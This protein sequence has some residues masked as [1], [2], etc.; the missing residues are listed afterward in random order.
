VC[1]GTLSTS[2]ATSLPRGWPGLL[3]A[4]GRL[5]NAVL[6]FVLVAAAAV[7]MPMSVIEERRR[8]WAT[9][10]PTTKKCSKC[11]AKYLLR[12]CGAPS[13]RSPWHLRGSRSVCFTGCERAVLATKEVHR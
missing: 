6:A 5:K 7:I 10:D 12:H 3:A 11:R 8:G 4:D 9:P 2:S 13:G 1:D